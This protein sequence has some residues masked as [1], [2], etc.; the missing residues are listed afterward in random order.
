MGLPNRTKPNPPPTGSPPPQSLCVR[1]RIRTVPTQL[2]PRNRGE[3]A[4]RLKRKK[5]RERRGGEKPKTDLT[6]ARFFD[7][8][9]NPGTGE[10][11]GGEPRSDRYARNTPEEKRGPAQRNAFR[12][13]RGKRKRPNKEKEEKKKKKAGTCGHSP[14]L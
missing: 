14:E 2:K 11:R 13:V 3:G 8:T 12:R 7:G 10:R 5:R 1:V 9:I 6:A 4:P